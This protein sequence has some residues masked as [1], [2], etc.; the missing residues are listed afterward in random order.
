MSKGE[1]GG[2]DYLVHMRIIVWLLANYLAILM[3]GSM[4]FGFV[5]QL[6]KDLSIPTAV[7]VAVMTHIWYMDAAAKRQNMGTWRRVTYVLITG[8][9]AG[10]GVLRIAAVDDLFWPTTMMVMILLTVTL[11]AGDRIQGGRDIGRRSVAQLT[12]LAVLMAGV[13][14]FLHARGPLFD[15]LGEV[16]RTGSRCLFLP[17]SSTLPSELQGAQVLLATGSVLYAAASDGRNYRVP[18]QNTVYTFEPCD[19]EESQIVGRSSAAKP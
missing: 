3:M 10:W 2:R 9:A 13:L 5:I 6:S 18:V 1:T 16:P 11:L 7:L 12:M 8:A 17:R 19:R 4:F 15:P 14:G